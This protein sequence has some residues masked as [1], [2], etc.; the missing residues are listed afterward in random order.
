MPPAAS[1]KR[2][3][4]EELRSL[5]L[6]RAEV[7]SLSV[8]EGGGVMATCEEILALMLAEPMSTSMLPPA[9]MLGACCIGGWYEATWPTPSTV[10][11][12]LAELYG[13]CRGARWGAPWTMEGVVLVKAPSDPPDEPRPRAE[14]LPCVSFGVCAPGGRRPESAGGCRGLDVADLAE[15]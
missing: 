7:W 3:G 1:K 5:L 14:R 8:A 6:P 12:L 4:E 15:T 13:G 2:A 10:P 11:R 9:G